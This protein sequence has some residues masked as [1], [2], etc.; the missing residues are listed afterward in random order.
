[1]GRTGSGKSSMILTLF[2]IVEASGDR[3]LID[4]VDVS[5]FALKVLR[6]KKQNFNLP[7]E[8]IL[9]SGTIRSNR[10]PFE[11]YDDDKLWKVLD[12][13]GLKPSV[14]AVDGKMD[15]V[16][17]EGGEN[18]SVGMRQLL[19]LTPAMLKRPKVPLLDEYTP[20]LILKLIT[21][22]YVLI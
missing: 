1:V 12:R 17:V 19:C 16:R 3:I 15:A 8:S 7:H 4:D 20:R 22:V 6:Y 9:F 14:N 11:E 21:P 13:S 2:R 5:T 10:D 18:L